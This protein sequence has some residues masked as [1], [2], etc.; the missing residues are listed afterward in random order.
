MQAQEAML[1]EGRPE[2][3]SIYMA[4]MAALRRAHPDISCKVGRTQISVRNRYVFMTA[5]PPWRRL[6]GWPESYL[7]VTFGLGCR[8]ESPRIAQAVE[9][10]P[11]RW[12]HHVP[13]QRESELDAELLGWLEEAYQFALAK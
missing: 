1:F 7:L 4:L 10:Y 9:A 8:R 2:V 5:S 11:G 12:T 13:V 3:L 6:R